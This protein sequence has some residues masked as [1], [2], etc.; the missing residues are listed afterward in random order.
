MRISNTKLMIP[1]SYDGS[2][3]EVLFSVGQRPDGDAFPWN[4]AQIGTVNVARLASDHVEISVKMQDDNSDYDWH[5][6][7]GVI[8][9]HVVAGDFTDGA[10]AAG[11]FTTTSAIPLGATVDYAF[12]KNVVAW[13]DDTTAVVTIGDIDTGADRYMTGT[14]SVAATITYL[15][16][17]AVSGTAYHS[18][19]KTVKVTVTGASDFTAFVTAATP[20]LTFGVHYHM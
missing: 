1:D 19:A 17:G 4:D 3:P 20:A 11:T 9:Q 14:P 13:D 12:V 5:V 8:S 18:A 15:S 2:Q 7:D 10:A 6:T 16:V